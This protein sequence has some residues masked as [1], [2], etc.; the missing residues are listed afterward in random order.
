MR[1]CFFVL[2]LA[3]LLLVACNQGS[4][5][6]ES[7]DF[8]GTYN[9][10]SVD[11]HAVPYAPIHE[12]QQAPEIVSSSISLKDDGTFSMVMSYTNPSGGTISND[13]T[14]TYTSQGSDFNLKWEGAGQTKVTIEGDTLT[15]NNE[16]M[17][18]VYQK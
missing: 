9:L 3:S 16:G 18:F 2:F 13:F 15:L 11:G 10:V 5:T 1:K 12:G 6:E 14:G 4:K 17:L 8:T 7:Y